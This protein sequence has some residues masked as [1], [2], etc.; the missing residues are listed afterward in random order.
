M[1]LFGDLHDRYSSREHGDSPGDFFLR[2]PFP[3]EKPLYCS[4]RFSR[5]PF[6]IGLAEWD[7]SPELSCSTGRPTFPPR[8]PP[9]L[10]RSP[11]Y[12]L[13]R[14]CHHVLLY[15]RSGGAARRNCE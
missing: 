9:L 6:F 4:T 5:S 13:D 3:S 15:L 2:V 11:N 8:R 7:S 10:E 1:R 14:H 12:G